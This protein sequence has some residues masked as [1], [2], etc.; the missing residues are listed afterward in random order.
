MEGIK[1]AENRDAKRVCKKSYGALRTFMQNNPITDC[2]PKAEVQINQVIFL[3][4]RKVNLLFITQDYHKPV[5]GFSNGFR[6]PEIVL[7]KGWPIVSQF[8]SALKLPIV[9]LQYDNLTTQ[10]STDFVDKL[11]Q[12]NL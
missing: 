11:Q 3:H 8:N 2:Q 5:N 1:L 12:L 9:G 7:Q 4:G 6:Q 10:L